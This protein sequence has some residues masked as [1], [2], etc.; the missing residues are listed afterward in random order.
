MLSGTSVFLRPAD[1]MNLR[2]LSASTSLNNMSVAVLSLRVIMASIAV[3]S[4][5]M[6]VRLG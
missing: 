4:E 2:T 6:P 5:T 3:R 1:A